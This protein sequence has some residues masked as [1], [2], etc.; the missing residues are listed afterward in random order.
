MSRVNSSLRFI[1]WGGRCRSPP[2][3]AAASPNH[4]VRWLI[5]ISAVGLRSWSRTGHALPDQGTLKALLARTG[6][7]Y[8]SGPAHRFRRLATRSHPGASWLVLQLTQSHSSWHRVRSSSALLAV[9]LDRRVYADRWIDEGSAGRRP[10]A[11]SVVLASCAWRRSPP[12][13]VA[14]ST[15]RVHRRD[16]A[17]SGSKVAHYSMISALVSP[18]VRSRQQQPSSDRKACPRWSGRRSEAC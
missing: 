17:G 9:W 6:A 11:F 16:G 10:G 14:S 4:R 8:V 5:A 3:S 1:G 12:T 15:G 2:W 7:S 13:H 18:A